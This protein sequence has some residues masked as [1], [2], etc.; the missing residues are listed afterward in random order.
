MGLRW[1]GCGEQSVRDVFSY[2]RRRR[3]RFSKALKS[4]QKASNVFKDKRV[5]CRNKGL[6]PWSFTVKISNKGVKNM[7]GISQK[8]TSER[9]SNL[10]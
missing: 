8:E 10:Y 1:A 9:N 7:D 4:Y 6:W 5:R 2:S 3:P